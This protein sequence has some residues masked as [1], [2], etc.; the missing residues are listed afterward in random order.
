[1]FAI[2]TETQSMELRICDI[3]KRLSKN[4]HDLL[5]AQ[6]S[7][8]PCVPWTRPWR[9]CPQVIA[10]PRLAFSYASVADV[11]KVVLV[12]TRQQV[13]AWRASMRPHLSR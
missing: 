5:F 3:A 6:G 11:D 13:P 7:R 8:R 10:P 12:A 1:M 2:P 9:T 4:V